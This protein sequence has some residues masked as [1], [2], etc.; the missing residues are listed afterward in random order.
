MLRAGDGRAP[1]PRLATAAIRGMIAA[2]SNN[3]EA[4]AT[5]TTVLPFE[6]YT[7]ENL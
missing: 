7:R 1:L 3:S 4:K 5:T 2:V 6:I